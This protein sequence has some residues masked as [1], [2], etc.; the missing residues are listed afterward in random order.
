[1]LCGVRLH[2]LSHH[3]VMLMGHLGLI[4]ERERERE[5]E[6]ESLNSKTLF[7]KDCSLGSAKNL[8]NN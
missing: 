7:Y 8:S 6:R 2:A 5:R 4:P 1:M 3:T